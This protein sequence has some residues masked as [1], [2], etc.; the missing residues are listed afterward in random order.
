MIGVESSEELC[1]TLLLLLHFLQLILSHQSI[2][3]PFSEL[4]VISWA[5][6]ASSLVHF[7]IVSKEIYEKIIL[8]LI[9]CGL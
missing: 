2:A 7:L 3:L 1:E 8:S 9:A 5:H 4:I 6:S